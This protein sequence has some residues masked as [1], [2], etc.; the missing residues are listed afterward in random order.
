MPDGI[1]LIL[2]GLLSELQKRLGA[3][4]WY[5]GKFYV[6]ALTPKVSPQIG[7][8][9]I[10]NENSTVLLFQTF[11]GNLPNFIQTYQQKIFLYK[12]NFN[13]K[14]VPFLLRYCTCDWYCLR[15]ILLKKFRPNL[16]FSLSIDYV[17]PT[18]IKLTWLFGCGQE[19]LV[20]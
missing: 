16:A 4:G 15:L 17:S 12:T 3:H 18:Q 20:Y 13:T 14:V 19:F 5:T 2:S 10:G 9:N 7:N 8:I 11:I 6:W 1:I